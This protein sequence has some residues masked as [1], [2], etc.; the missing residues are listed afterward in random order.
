MKLY[1]LY[2]TLSRAKDIFDNYIMKDKE[3]GCILYEFTTYFKKSIPNIDLELPNG[4]KI[5]DL[6]KSS[7]GSMKNT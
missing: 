2:Y 4:V 6:K 7:K 3:N 1:N 5:D